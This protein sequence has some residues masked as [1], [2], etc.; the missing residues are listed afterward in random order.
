MQCLLLSD[1]VAPDPKFLFQVQSFYSVNPMF[2]YFWP[3]AVVQRADH[4]IHWISRYEADNFPIA[5]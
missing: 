1:V 3:H 4:F 2:L 5:V